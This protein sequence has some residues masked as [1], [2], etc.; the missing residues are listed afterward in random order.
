MIISFE[1]YDHNR[2]YS[3]PAN[4][5]LA[6]KDLIK[7]MPSEKVHLIFSCH[8]R[9]VITSSYFVG[10]LEEISS[11]YADANEMWHYCNTEGLTRGPRAELQ[12]AIKRLFVPTYVVKPQKPKD[13]LFDKYDSYYVSRPGTTTEVTLVSNKWWRLNKTVKFIWD[14]KQNGNWLHH[15]EPTCALNFIERCKAYFGH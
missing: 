3:G 9:Q 4:G 1:E 5:K 2:L 13:P 15:T 8:P 10:L 14:A 7:E 6:R 11:L 12:R